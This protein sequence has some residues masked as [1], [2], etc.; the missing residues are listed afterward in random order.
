MPPHN[1]STRPAC[2]WLW[3]GGG[4]SLIGQKM[5]N[6]HME[7][8]TNVWKCFLSLLDV[9]GRNPQWHWVA[10][11]PD[12]AAVSYYLQGLKLGMWPLR[13]SWQR[14]EWLNISLFKQSTFILCLWKEYIQYVCMRT[15]RH[16]VFFFTNFQNRFFSV[17]YQYHSVNFWFTPLWRVTWLETSHKK[18]Q[19]SS[20]SP[21]YVT[22][23]TNTSK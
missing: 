9:L 8:I 2:F 1:G 5:P 21:Y 12:R 22:S 4:I 19:T 18:C 15:P 20:V 16:V 17:F 14:K 11:D 7:T 3:E 10:V 23:C 13:S 6:K